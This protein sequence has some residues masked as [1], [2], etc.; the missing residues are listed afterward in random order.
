MSEALKFYVASRASIPER[1][2]MW[3]KFRSQGHLIISTW[4][5][6]AGEGQTAC[7]TE[8]WSRIEAEIQASDALILYIEPD[9][10]PLK[11]AFIEAGMAIAMGKPVYIVAPGVILDPKNFKPIGSWA[12][13]PL[14]FFSKDVKSVLSSAGD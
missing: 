7:L 5:D 11:G 12:A 6:E 4:I 1:S 13:H 9:D 10:F 3:R 14:V 2:E 8:L